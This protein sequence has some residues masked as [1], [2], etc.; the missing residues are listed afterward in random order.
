MTPS[1]TWR[2]WK[3]I[4]AVTTRGR[5]TWPSRSAI[6]GG[7]W[8]WIAAAPRRSRRIV[9][10]SS[11][12]AIHLGNVAW[13]HKAAGRFAEAV[14]ADE[15]SLD[16]RRHLSESD[17]KDD[18]ARGRL[19]F[20]L[21]NLANSGPTLGRHAEALAHAR[22]AVAIADA[23]RSVD[24]Q[25]RTELVDYLSNSRRASSGRRA[26]STPREPATA[27][28]AHDLASQTEITAKKDRILA[29]VAE[30]L[31]ACGSRLP[32]LAHPRP[33]PVSHFGAILRQVWRQ[34]V[35]HVESDGSPRVHARGSRQPGRHRC[36]RR[37]FGPAIGPTTVGSQLEA[38]TRAS[39]ATTA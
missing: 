16:I 11:I 3:N 13:I 25:N 28:R 35:C 2:W 33:L 17:P 39:S 8:S 24:S 12:C 34:G 26:G 10:H 18:Y 21:N 7:R 31:E 36:R 1:E 6:T 30:G 15:Q 37:P 19:A 4:S 9:R 5:A 32:S 27:R 22:E 23:R 29:R 20:V 38:R 14:A